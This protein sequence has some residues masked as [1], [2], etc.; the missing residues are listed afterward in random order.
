MND[1]IL[2]ELK[3]Q[4][5]LLEKIAKS[6]NNMDIKSDKTILLMKKLAEKTEGL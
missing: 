1:D 3:I 2:E 5:I 4:T 6:L